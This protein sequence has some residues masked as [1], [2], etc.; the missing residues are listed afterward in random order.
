MTNIV[1]YIH[2]PTLLLNCVLIATQGKSARVSLGL[3]IPFKRVGW[4]TRLQRWG[5][6]RGHQVCRGHAGVVTVGQGRG[7]GGDT[8]QDEGRETGG[9]GGEQPPI[10]AILVP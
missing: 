8:E 6:H 2:S 4:S 5:C 7:Q 1:I 9:E 10:L 3:Y